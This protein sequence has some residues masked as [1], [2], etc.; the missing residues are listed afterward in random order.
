MRRVIIIIVFG[1]ALWPRAA[2]AQPL[3]KTEHDWTM[4]VGDATFGLRQSVQ[5]PGEFRNTHVYLGWYDFRTRFLASHI[6]VAMTLL[7][8]VGAALEIRSERRRLQ[9]KT[10]NSLAED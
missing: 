5:T 9:W 8:T 7:L 3:F 4:T 2:S 10:P 6:V 1:F